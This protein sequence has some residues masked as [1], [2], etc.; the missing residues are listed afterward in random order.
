VGGT[1]QAIRLMYAMSVVR[2]VNGMVDSVQKGVHARSVSALA[3]ELGLPEWVV[4]FR[5]DA[6]HTALPTLASCRMTGKFILEWLRFRYWETQARY[7]PELQALLKAALK[8]YTSI[9]VQL[10]ALSD[11]EAVT[12][13]TSSQTVPAGKGKKKAKTVKPTKKPIASNT[14]SVRALFEDRTAALDEVVRLCG[15]R[16]VACEMLI[17]MLL[18]TGMMVPVDK[19]MRPASLLGLG[20]ECIDADP[21]NLRAWSAALGHFE[22]AWPGFLSDMLSTM[23]S[24][25]AAVSQP[26]ATH[27]S[28]SPVDVVTVHPSPSRLRSIGELL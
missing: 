27:A 23:V 9:E 28:E 25:L 4:D 21:K 8:H 3:N 14:A 19:R 22:R 10:S 6:T 18:K 26:A 2:F 17:P 7:E 11:A 16:G 1:S 5:H 15:S 24:T 20:V 13:A 12:M